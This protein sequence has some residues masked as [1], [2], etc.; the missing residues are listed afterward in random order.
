[1]AINREEQIKKLK[2]EGNPELYE[3]IIYMQEEIND[4]NITVRDLSRTVNQLES[5]NAV[6]GSF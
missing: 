6:Y 2:L 1:M 4:L 3:L 5:R